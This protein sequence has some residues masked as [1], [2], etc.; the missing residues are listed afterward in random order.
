MSNTPGP[1]GNSSSAEI[2]CVE[3]EKGGTVS[4]DYQPGSTVF[5][6]IQLHTLNRLALL[7]MGLRCSTKSTTETETH[8]DPYKL[9]GL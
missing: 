1:G 7:V 8:P 5:F 4:V 9:R 6:N 2:G 3:P